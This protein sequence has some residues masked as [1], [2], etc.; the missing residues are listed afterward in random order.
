MLS[1]GARHAGGD[2]QP[3]A[4]RLEAW[5]GGCDAFALAILA[6]LAATLVLAALTLA[7]G[8][9]VSA[10]HWLAGVAL[11]DAVFVARLAPSGTGR[12]VAW[13]AG[14]LAAVALALVV[15]GRVY[16]MSFDGQ[17]YHLEGVLRLARGWNPFWTWDIP[18]AEPGVDAASV[19]HY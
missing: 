3:R 13:A 14:W 2:D 6:A 10:W 7:L 19:T 11:G 8:G 18:G 4:S 16:D 9:H 1:E 5:A 15:A 17:N 12:R